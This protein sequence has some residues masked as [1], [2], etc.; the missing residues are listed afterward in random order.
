M[1]GADRMLEMDFEL[2]LTA[3]LEEIYGLQVRV[4]G[5][6]LNRRKAGY[7]TLRFQYAYPSRDPADAKVDVSVVGQ[8][9]SSHSFRVD[10]TCADSIEQAAAGCEDL[11]FAIGPRATPEA[12]SGPG[13]SGKPPRRREDD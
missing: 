2:A 7:T 11:A 9:G 4:D 6:P 3:N 12:R 1:A 10:L 8:N 5:D 13:D